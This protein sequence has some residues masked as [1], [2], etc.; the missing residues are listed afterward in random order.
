VDL[1]MSATLAFPRGRTG[2]V[3]ASFLADESPDVVTTVHGSS[4]TLEITS[5]YVPQWGG[6]LR[7]IAGESVVEEAADPTPSYVFQL[8][9]LVRCVRDR[10]PVLTSA[11]DG[12][13]TM[14]AV[15]DVYEAAGL[16]RRG[17]A[18]SAVS[19]TEAN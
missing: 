10:A 13:R 17:T 1:G 19:T 8:R 14:R 11:A 12:V 4:G 16:A 5:L 7:I 6:R 15:D 18:P 2:A 3:R 9:E